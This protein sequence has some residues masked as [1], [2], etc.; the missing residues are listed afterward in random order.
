[1]SPRSILAIVPDKSLT[2][3]HRRLLHDLGFKVTIA[4]TGTEGLHAALAY[5]WLLIIIGYALPD[6]A[7]YDILRE[8]RRSPRT[9]SLPMVILGTQNDETDTVTALELGADDYLVEPIG[10]RVFASRIRSLI[11]QVAH[12]PPDQLHTIE[13]QGIRINPGQRDVFIGNTKVVLTASEF[14]LLHFLASHPGHAFRRE[15]I[16]LQLRG[17]ENLA[18]RRAVDV[19]IA[20]LRRRLGEYGNRI[21]TVRGVGY[22]LR[23]H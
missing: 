15:E 14:E 20:G 10:P 13:I 19:Q 18:S 17:N 12:V 22:R 5:R 3:E 6:M 11:R 1:M 23:T 7:G 16:L 9:A 2:E 21:E 8:L 4:S